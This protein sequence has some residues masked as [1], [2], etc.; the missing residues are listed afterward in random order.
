MGS[1]RYLEG[2]LSVD[3]SVV[4]IIPMFGSTPWVLKKFTKKPWIRVGFG[5]GPK[6]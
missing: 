6:L 5:I 4:G 3:G 2:G 1:S